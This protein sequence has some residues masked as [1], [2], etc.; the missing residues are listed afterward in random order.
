MPGFT[1]ECQ[2][3]NHKACSDNGCRCG[4]HP[5]TQELLKAQ[6]RVS[7]PTFPSAPSIELKNTCPKC[8]ASAKATDTFC[9]RDGER[10]L[11]GKQCLKCRA[12]QNPEDQF[13]WQCGLK[14]GEQAP[15]DGEVEVLPPE[16]AASTQELLLRLRA[17]AKEKELRETVVR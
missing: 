8:G 5:W 6:P 16:N 10:L 9:R 12:P 15:V 3:G 4:C 11:Q 17:Y 14:A 2:T 7:T 13:C 1:S